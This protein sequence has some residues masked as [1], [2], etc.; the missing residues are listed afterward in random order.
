MTVPLIV[1]KRRVP[2]FLVEIRTGGSLGN[3]SARA[4]A[5]E[6]MRDH[7]R[8]Y[9]SGSIP[10]PKLIGISSFGTKFCVYTFTTETWT[11]EL[12]LIA[13]DTRV[14]NNVAPEDRWA[15]DV[16]TEEGEVKLRELVAAIKVMGANL[17]GF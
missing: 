1:R 2:V 9:S 11:L 16:L 12:E 10:T 13:A 4:F 8:E 6:Q 17:W 5:D 14:V 7:L 15:F 3:L